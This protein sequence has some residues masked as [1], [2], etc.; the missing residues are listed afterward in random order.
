MIGPVQRRRSAA[1]K[2]PMRLLL[3][4]FEDVSSYENRT[5]SGAIKAIYQI[6]RATHMPGCLFLAMRCAT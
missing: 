6:L 1:S 2:R 5:K 3:M 4:C